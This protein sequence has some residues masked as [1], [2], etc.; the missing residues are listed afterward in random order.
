MS[1]GRSDQFI[2]HAMSERR[3]N[4]A[5]SHETNRQYGNSGSTARSHIDHLGQ[6]LDHIRPIWQVRQRVVQRMVGDTLF[7]L[8]DR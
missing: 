2:G 7:A 5:H 4:F 6:D 8:G 3:R 1:C